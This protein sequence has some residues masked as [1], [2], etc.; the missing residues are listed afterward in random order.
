MAGRGPDK[1]PRKPRANKRDHILLCAMNVFSY[2]GYDGASLDKIALEAGVAKALIIKYFGTKERLA[3]ACVMDFIERFAHAVDSIAAEEPTYQQ[4]VQRVSALFKHYKKELRFLLALSITPANAHFAEHIW[5]SMYTEK[6]AL[7][8]KY[9]E[10]IGPDLFPDMIR[11]MAALHFS[12]VIMDDEQRY[13]SARKTML[14]KYL[15]CDADG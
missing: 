14:E 10:Q 13:D 12:Y 1:K 2:Y 7:I 15:G 3:E 5:L 6:H 8:I 9:R 4:N 11:S